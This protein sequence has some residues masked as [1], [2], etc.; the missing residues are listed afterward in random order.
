VSH[1]LP[2]IAG[3]YRSKFMNSFNA[4]LNGSLSG[5]LSWEQWEALC[6]RILDGSNGW[7]VYAVG[8]GIPDSELNGAALAVVL[9]EIDALLRRDHDQDYCGI[10]YVDDFTEPTLIKIY[11]PNNLGSSCGSSGRQIPP[12][13]ILSR[14]PPEPIAS[15]IPLPNN[16]RRWWQGLLQ[17]LSPGDSAPE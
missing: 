13:W 5:V 3:E 8:N 9:E 4:I 17:K 11:D 6:Q 10:V 15:D 16:R 14:M 2:Q 1:F 12:G 7:Y